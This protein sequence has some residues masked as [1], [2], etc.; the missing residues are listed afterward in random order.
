MGRKILCI[1][2]GGVR[3][4]GTIGA[5]IKAEEMGIDFSQF[6]IIQATSSGTII[7]AMLIAGL[8]PKEIERRALK[9]PLNTFIDMGFLG[10]KFIF[11]GVSNGGI[12]KWADSLNLQPTD[13]FVINTFDKTKNKQYI[14]TKEDYEKY[15]YG[16]ALRCSTCYPGV[17]SPIDGK[18]LDGGIV[19]NPIMLNLNADDE[20]LCIYLGYAGEVK[21]NKFKFNLFRRLEEAIYAVEFLNYRSFLFMVDKFKSIDIIWPKIYDVASTNFWINKTDMENMIT[22]GKIN[23]ES[24]WASILHKW[25]KK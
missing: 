9:L 5:L 14:F 24:Q 6:D 12:G 19:E 23:S 11:G 8:T 15:G 13:K 1:G 25:V 4:Y 3:I 20:I 17:M 16:Y 7:A 10:L 22:N 21:P 18:Y 2:G